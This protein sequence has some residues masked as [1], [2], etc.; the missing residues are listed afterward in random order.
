VSEPP[1]ATRGPASRGG[2]KPG[3]RIDPKGKHALFTA[4]VTSAPDQ[5]GPGNQKE[6]RQALF[7]TGP[8]RVGTVVVHCDACRARARISLVDLGIRL[9]SISFWLPGRERP[10]WMRCPACHRHTWCS[11]D[12]T[13]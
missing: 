10:H 8:R 5:L 9:A 13:G 6:G 11:I 2:R 1:P 7:S 4:P 3:R 12:W